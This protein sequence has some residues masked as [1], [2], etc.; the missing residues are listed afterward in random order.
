[1]WRKF[2]LARQSLN[3]EQDYAGKRIQGKRHYQEDD[4][5][6]DN[7][8]P[9]D[10]L[11]ILADGMGGHKGGAVASRCVIQTFMDTYHAVAGNVADRL[12]QALQQSNRQLALT[13]QAKPDLEGMGCT[14][15]GVTIHN[16]QL[17]WISVGDSPLWRYHAGRLQRLNADHSMKS[18]LQK[19]V[20]HGKLTPEEAATHPERNIIFSAITGNLVELLDFSFTPL[21]LYPGNRILLASDGIFTLSEPE[22]C[23]ILQKNLSAQALVNK[24]LNAVENKGKRDQDNTTVLVVKIPDELDT[25]KKTKRWHWK[26]NI[27]LFLFIFSIIVWISVHFRVMNLPELITHFSE[28]LIPTY[29]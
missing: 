3:I 20:L 19:M 28:I 5:G 23:K 18:L 29:P 16:E 6:F 13:V 25:V 10:F 11:M 8:K 7:S 14:L 1:M 27:L 26:T 4:F 22:I 9:N 17:E 2:R 15:V 24:L 21:E 12:L